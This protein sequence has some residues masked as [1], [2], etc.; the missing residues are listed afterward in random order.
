MR[1]IMSVDA[2][3]SASGAAPLDPEHPRVLDLA[4]RLG[5]SPEQAAARLGKRLR[6]GR[7]WLNLD[8]AAQ[9][10]VLQHQVQSL[11]QAWA[12][13]L[14]ERL[15]AGARHVSGAR[16]DD[17]IAVAQREL[18][19]SRAVALGYWPAHGEHPQLIARKILAAMRALAPLVPLRPHGDSELGPSVC[20]K[21]D[22]LHYDADLWAELVTTA[23]QTGVRLHVDAQGLET[24]DPAMRLIE[25]AQGRGADLSVTLP[26][27][28]GR[29]FS[30]VEQFLYWR[31]PIRLVK[32]Q[33]GD[34]A[35]PRLDP[36][37]AFVALAERLAGRA[38]HVGVATHDA[39]S[40]RRVLALLDE[41]GTSCALEQ[42]RSLPRLDALADIMGLPV[43]A[44]IAYGQTGLPYA[45]REVL[46]RP[47]ML[48]W[49]ARDAWAARRLTRPPTPATQP[50][51]QG[52]SAPGRTGG[53]DA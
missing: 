6:R 25:A 35:H 47:A 44:Y 12:Q 20:V 37:E 14:A 32:G 7:G 31:L 36:R 28:W 11:Q 43:R 21:L 16:L 51:A 23:R 39:R 13:R 30:D 53:R 19:E 34:P 45:L 52:R 50:E 10:L 5:Q 38:R 17:A 24:A 29:S 26:A 2:S 48:G 22:L 8:R 1:T 4:L 15:A 27:R 46:R 9:S 49:M 42:L 33:G 41:A 3:A 40:A 18:A